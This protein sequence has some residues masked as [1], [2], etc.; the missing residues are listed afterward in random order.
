[1]TSCMAP[2]NT[3]S[4][5]PPS[6]HAAARGYIDCILARRRLDTNQGTRTWRTWRAWRKGPHRGSLAAPTPQGP[7]G[8][9]PPGL[10][11][12]LAAV[13][14]MGLKAAGSTFVCRAQIGSLDRWGAHIV[15]LARPTG[16]ESTPSLLRH[17]PHTSSPT[18][19]L[20]CFAVQRQPLTVIDCEGLELAAWSWILLAAPRC[21]SH[22]LARR[23]R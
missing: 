18:A 15:D 2:H 6:D 20:S 11:E 14:S 13:A 4:T 9:S 7:R 16:R 10:P 21:L 5:G 19:A 22:Q 17:H 23:G 8:A 12:L 1:M 3:P